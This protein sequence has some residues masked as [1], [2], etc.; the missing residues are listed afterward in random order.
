[1]LDAELAEHVTVHDLADRGVSSVRMKDAFLNYALSD[2]LKASLKDVCR[3]RIDGGIRGFVV[4]LAA[5]TV[6][7]SCGLSVLISIKKLVEGEGGRV[8]LSGLSPMIERLFGITK[9]DRV[10]EIHA[11]E[12]AAVAALSPPAR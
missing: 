3:R 6:M 9:L 10:F 1:M 11:D 7:D 2:E 4:D 12:A 5:V 8:A